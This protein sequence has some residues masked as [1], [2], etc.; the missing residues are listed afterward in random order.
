VRAFCAPDACT[1]RQLT[2]L[3]EAATGG[4]DTLI[5]VSTPNGPGGGIAPPE[6][7]DRLGE[8]SERNGHL[9]VLDGCYQ[10][11]AGPHDALLPRVGERTLVVHSLS[12]SHGLA[13][14]R[15]GLVFGTRE[16]LE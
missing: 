2:E 8:E 15:V 6:L 13:G 9:L 3:V 4:R 11:F 10:S 16:R 1:E 7:L 14:A 5:A 12:K